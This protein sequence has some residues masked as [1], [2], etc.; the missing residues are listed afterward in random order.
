MQYAK[1]TQYKTRYKYTVHTLRLFFFRNTAYYYFRPCWTYGFRRWVLFCYWV[2]VQTLKRRKN[3][4]GA[5]T[6]LR[7]NRVAFCILGLISEHFHFRGYLYIKLTHGGLSKSVGRL[8]CHC[9]CCSHRLFCTFYL[10][11]YS[12]LFQTSTPQRQ[13]V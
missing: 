12:I 11:R 3:L 7:V 1:F 10:F 6:Y 8:V 9:C 4:H 5:F 13:D 2:D